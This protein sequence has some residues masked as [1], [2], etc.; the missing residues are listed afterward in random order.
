MYYS[1]TTKGFYDQ[2]NTLPPDAVQISKERYRELLEGDAAGK[3]IEA[4]EQGYPILVDPV[5]V[6][7]PYDLKRRREYPPLTDLADALYW[8]S[9]GD[10]TKMDAYLAA[11]EA[12]K[13]K[14]P[15]P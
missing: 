15:K 6:E 13:I 4:D 5:V 12:V 3:N 1:K 10:Q 8:Q 11:V 7:I 2:T 9:Q 14:Y